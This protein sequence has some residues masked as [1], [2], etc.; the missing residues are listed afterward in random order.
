[1]R[2]SPA[3][4][5]SSKP[6]HRELRGT[7][8]DSRSA[9]VEKLDGTEVV[10]GDEGRRSAAVPGQRSPRRAPRAAAGPA[11]RSQWKTMG[12]K[13]AAAIALAIAGL[14][15]AIGRV[16]DDRIGAYRR[17][18]HGRGRSGASVAILAA[19]LVVGAETTVAPIGRAGH[20][21]DRHPT[22]EQ[23]PRLRRAAGIGEED[24]P[25][26]ALFEQALERRQSRPSPRPACC[27]TW[28]GSR[29][30]R[31]ERSTCFAISA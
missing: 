9:H 21:D 31:R 22:L 8:I 18:A 12:S 29:A 13:P 30:P 17:S 1:M 5:T 25:G 26:D 27:R 19:A 4:I 15:G 16:L 7:G 24:D 6:D 2:A 23:G 28:R 3:I 14:A 10:G 11:A 20:E